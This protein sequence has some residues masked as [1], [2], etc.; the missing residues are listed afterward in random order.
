MP[1]Y[2]RGT[3]IQ[4]AR[5]APGLNVTRSQFHEK[6][7]RT[8][9]IERPPDSLLMVFGLKGHADFQLDGMARPVR[10]STGECWLIEPGGKPYGRTLFADVATSFFVVAFQQGALQDPLRGAIEDASDPGRPARQLPVDAASPGY[11]DDLFDPGRSKAGLLRAQGSCLQLI[12]EMLE[13]AAAAP[14]GLE[15]RVKSYLSDHLSSS[16]SLAEVARHCGMSH[17]RLNRDFKQASGQTV[18]EYLR[19]LR[20]ERAVQLLRQTSDPISRI[21]FDCGFS[22]PSHLSRVIRARLGTTPRALR[23]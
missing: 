21:A 20:L 2:G 8:A 10:I 13:A 5:L 16:V 4:V 22:N 1:G 19:E 14:D 23:G 6:N 18:F 17:V 12:G 15:H 7:N 9:V 11:I 3:T